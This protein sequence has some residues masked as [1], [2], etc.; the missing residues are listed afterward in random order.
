[1]KKHFSKDISFISKN[2]TILVLITLLSVS[3]FFNIK[4]K[5]EL[6]KFLIKENIKGTYIM[7]VQD[8]SNSKYLVFTKDKF[9]RYKQF[10]E[11]E[12]G[13]YE[14]VYDDIYVLKNDNADEYII[15]SN[16]K[17]YSYNR[18]Q[19]NILIYS[20]TSSIPMFINAKK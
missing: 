12:E 15:Y 11:L 5:T 19:N 4:F 20:K 10:E 18:N 2:S 3:F 7:Q 9:Y 1:V 17:L 8:I 14:N 16:E 6:D 13:S